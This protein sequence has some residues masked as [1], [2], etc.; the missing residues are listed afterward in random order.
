MYGIQ[1]KSGKKNNTDCLRCVMSLFKE[2]RPPAGRM[3]FYRLINVELLT[4]ARDRGLPCGPS[5]A[6]C[7]MGL[8]GADSL[9]VMGVGRNS[10]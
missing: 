3:H 2:A 9:S 1:C 10:V 8:M 5:T 4:S 6:A 7:G